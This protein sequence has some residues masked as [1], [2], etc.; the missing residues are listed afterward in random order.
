M[1]GQPI[2]VFSVLAHRWVLFF[3]HP[4]KQEERGSGV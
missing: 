3:E 1:V 4:S 2:V